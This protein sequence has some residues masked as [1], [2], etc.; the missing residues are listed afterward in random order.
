[1]NV[2]AYFCSYC[3]PPRPKRAYATVDVKYKGGIWIRLY[4]DFLKKQ[5]SVWS[6]DREMARVVLEHFLGEKVT[7][8]EVCRLLAMPAMGLTRL[9]PK[10]LE[11][12]RQISF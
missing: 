6:R 4:K 2:E 7:E 11:P 3:F 5:E 12:F 9:E 10:E 1:M 8:A